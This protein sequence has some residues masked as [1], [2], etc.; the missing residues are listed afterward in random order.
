MSA[1]VFY[2]PHQR[3]WRWFTRLSQAV[4]IFASLA[5]TAVVA[6]ILINPALP[7]LGLPPVAPLP[8]HRLLPPRPERPPRLGERKLEASK[9]A[10]HIE[11]AK[12]SCRGA[13]RRPR[14]APPSSTRSSSTGT[15]PASPRSSRTS[16]ASTSWCPN[17]CTWPTRPGGSSRT[18]RRAGRSCSISLEGSAAGSPGRA[19]HQQLQP[20]HARLAVG[21]HRR[22]AGQPGGACADD[23]RVS[24]RSWASTGSKGINVDFEA[25]PKARQRPAGLVHVRAEG[26]VP[27]ARLV[28]VGIGA[29]R[30][31]R[32]R[33]QGARRLHRLPDPDGVRRARQR[34]GRRAGG[35]TVLV[36]RRRCPASN[37][38]VRR[39]RP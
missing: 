12:A 19:A 11:R 37:T 5:A 28:R 31:Q 13:S 7:G 38:M 33:L 4:G 25:I 16:G 1:P 22:D 24:P 27:A 30:R 6:T 17:G 8:Q 32:V 9:R 39:A 10:L 29:A 34:I 3:R 20:R 36:Q 35:V 26:R 14:H 18:T 23:C 2:D 15:T 21:A